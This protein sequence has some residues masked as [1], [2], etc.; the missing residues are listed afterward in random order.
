M[1]L[2]GAKLWLDIVETLEF[3]GSVEFVERLC[4][5]T[6]QLVRLSSTDIADFA[7]F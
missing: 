6:C 1:A 2:F 4:K 3:F 7:D 5:V